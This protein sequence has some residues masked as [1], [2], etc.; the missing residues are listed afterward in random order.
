MASNQEEVN[1]NENNQTSYHRSHAR[2]DGGFV[3]DGR[4]RDESER[5]DLD[6]Q[7]AAR[8]E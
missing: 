3:R 1:H 8:G 7:L 6:Q 5:P 2:R 4:D